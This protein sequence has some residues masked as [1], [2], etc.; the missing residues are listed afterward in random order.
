MTSPERPT[1]SRARRRLGAELRTART[2]AGLG[3]ADLTKALE[4][5]QGV[6][7]R[8]ETGHRLLTVDETHAWLQAV[9]ADEDTQDR[10]LALTEAVHAET[11][12]W[13]TVYGGRS[14][15]QDVIGD[16]DREC[17]VVRNFQ[18]TV[19]PGMLQTVDYARAVIRISDGQA[20]E[21]PGVDQVAALAGRIG[22]QE[23]LRE[24]GRQFQFVFVEGLLHREPQEGV[25]RAQLAQLITFSELETVELAV[26]PASYMGT[27]PWHNFILRHPANGE[28]PF[29]RAELLHGQEE[30][31]DVDSVGIYLGL[32]DRLW[33]ASATG[34]AAVDMIRAAMA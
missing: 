10:I 32:W 18:P 20:Y 33:E 13:S 2:L 4:R 12:L 9:R 23:L 16:M 8:V 11:S 7:S 31:R 30:I 5:T 27:M 14:H 1:P 6:V 17:A 15:L 3:Q 28:P 26:L 34:D 24:P 25:L 19:L 22:R 21:V 29:A